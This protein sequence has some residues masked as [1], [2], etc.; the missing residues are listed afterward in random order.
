MATEIIKSSLT[1]DEII[2]SIQILVDWEA[3]PVNLRELHSEQ[4]SKL[5]K[6]S[7]IVVSASSVKAKACEISSIYCI[8]LIV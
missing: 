2:P 4:V 8:R 6:I 1:S 3:S 7:G 5:V